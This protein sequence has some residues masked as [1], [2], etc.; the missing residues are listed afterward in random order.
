MRVDVLPD[1]VEGNAAAEAESAGTGR[2]AAIESMVPVE[3][4]VT[5]TVPDVAVSADEST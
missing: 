5:L 4:A 2:A 3:S 1:V